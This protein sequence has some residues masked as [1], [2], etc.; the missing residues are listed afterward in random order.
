VVYVSRRED[1]FMFRE[2]K[3]TQIAAEF[4]KRAG[5]KMEYIKLLKLLYYADR[6]M[7]L[8][9]GIP[10]TYDRWYVMKCGP[11]LSATYDLIKENS[12]D[13]WSKYIR[14][15][16]YNVTL[17]ADPGNDELSRAESKI[18]D[19][20]FRNHAH[21][22]KWDLVRDTHD[23]PEWENLGAGADEITYR[24]VLEVEGIPLSE[25]D[26]IVEKIEAENEVDRIL[27]KAG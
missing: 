3:T 17:Q 7:L 16:G 8:R 12:G 6:E 23:L 22:E 4:L 1:T 18:I 2:E 21:K 10:M 13:T 26:K 27:A 20:T 5:G 25:I 9:W 11:V 15:Q 24:T 14:S 19:E